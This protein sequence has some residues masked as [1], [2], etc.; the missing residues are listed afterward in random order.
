MINSGQWRVLSLLVAANIF[1]FTFP[2]KSTRMCQKHICKCLHLQ[3][4]LHNTAEVVKW[5]GGGSEPF[6]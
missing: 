4:Q 6:L 1:Y 3:L 2:L 5:V